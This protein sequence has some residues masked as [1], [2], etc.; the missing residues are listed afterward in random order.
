MPKKLIKNSYNAGE[1]SSYMDGRTDI[2]KYYNGCSKLINATVLP[3]GG[4]VK[5]SGTIYIAKAPSKCKLFPFEFSVD[6][7]LVL[8][9]SESLI[10][11]Y[12]NDDRVYESDIEIAST[13]EDNPV[14][15]TTDATHNLIDGEWVYLEDI[16]TATSLNDKIYR[17]LVTGAG[18]ATK[19]FLK[20]TENNNING[21]GIGVGGALGSCKRV[22]QITS[23]YTSAQAFQIHYT[24]SADV[25]YIAHEDVHP[26]KLS[27]L[28]DTNWTITDVPFKAGAFLEENTEPSYTFQF[29]S[30]AKH[31]GGGVAALTDSS[32]AWTVNKYIGRV[33]YNITQNGFATITA[34]SATTIT[35]AMDTGNWANDDLY[36]IDGYFIEGMEGTLEVT[37]ATPFQGTVADIGSLWRLKSSMFASSTTTPDN[38]TNARPDD[39]TNAI[40]I[41]GDFN[42][43]CSNLST[44]THMAKLWRKPLMGDWEEVRSFTAA[45]SYPS[46]EKEDDVWYCWTENN[47]AVDGTLTVK[48]PINIGIVKIT[49]QTD[50]NT[51]TVEIVSE[52]QQSKAIAGAAANAVETSVDT[53]RWSE[54]AWSIYRGYPRTVGF[55]ED[56]L[57]WWSSTN[58]P[59]TGWS[60]KTGRYEDMDYSDLGLDTDAI[61]V[62]LRDNEVSQVQWMMARQVMAIGTANKEYRFSATNPD[63]SVTPSDKKA[64]PQTG[65]G[66]GDIQPVILNDSIFFFQRQ[67]RKLWAMKFDSISEN[68]VAEDVT[69]LA[70]TLLESQPVC[71]AV[72]RVPD[73]IIWVVR[74]DGVLLSFTYEP[75]E[76]VKGWARHITQNTGGVGTPAGYFE[77]VAVIHGSVEDDVWVSV[78]REINGVTV[79]YIEKFATRFFDQIDEA[80]MLDSAVVVSSAYDAQEIVLASDTVRCNNGLCNSSLCGGV[81]A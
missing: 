65:I 21:T 23:P 68:F 54:G 58:N 55:F 72:Q 30:T 59:D 13:T 1:L 74:T 4:V 42:F 76:E 7:A 53:A 27:R 33:L 6:D 79:R 17:V 60:S 25:I 19:F 41:K 22:Y 15:V 43:S 61:T 81:I 62:P 5:R 36:N 12:K 10:R 50:T 67:G 34:N 52:L 71:M 9:F 48:N 51:A 45:A 46:T 24:Q 37:N 78:R 77:S 66:S 38:D 11:F 8:E 73:S 31:D 56:R 49:T 57:W 32:Q 47:A 29:T 28:G 18:G 2:S 80:Q 69:L 16:D 64:I 40:K 35:A 44:A 3:H 70:N 63:N 39:L 14:L 75:D 26:K 20:D